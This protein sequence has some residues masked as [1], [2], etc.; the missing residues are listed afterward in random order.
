ME[1]SSIILIGG[2]SVLVVVSILV[3][4]FFV[5]IKE[6]PQGQDIPSLCYSNLQPSNYFS[7]SSFLSSERHYLVGLDGSNSKI[8]IDLNDNIFID[9]KKDGQLFLGHIS[10]T[11]SMRPSLPDGAWLIYLKP[12]KQDIKVGDIISVEREGKKNLLHRVVEIT[13]DGR[14]ITKGDNNK[15]RDKEIWNFSQIKGKV[16]GVIY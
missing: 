10:K 5:I 11:G 7:S 3:I 9:N 14:Y 2:I 16:I 1:K 13:K 15:R 6:N 8:S 12:K 4:V